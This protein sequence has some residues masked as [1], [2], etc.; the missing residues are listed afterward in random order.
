MT[1]IGRRMALTSL[2]AA[3]AL[4]VQGCRDEEQ[5][6]ILV[7]EKGVYQGERDQKLEREQVDAL[8]SRARKQQF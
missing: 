2:L 5:D 1:G 8:A 7:H 6:R 3:L 4:G